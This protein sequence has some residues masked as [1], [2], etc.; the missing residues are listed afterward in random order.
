MTSIKNVEVFNLENN[1]I[2]EISGDFKDFTSNWKEL[3]L[4]NN[5]LKTL[6]PSIFRSVLVLDVFFNNINEAKFHDSQM[7]ELAIPNNNLTLL[8]IGDN[9]E[10]LDVSFN[11]RDSFFIDFKNNKKLIHLN[12]AGSDIKLSD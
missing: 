9:F 11:D 10:K 7:I 8:T 1:Q 2:K 4:Q 6:D 12:W 3:F 5:Q